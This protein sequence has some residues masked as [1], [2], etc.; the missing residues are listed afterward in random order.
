MVNSKGMF[1][2]AAVAAAVSITS[3][4]FGAATPSE[5][6]QATKGG[7]MGKYAGCVFKAR[8]SLLLTGDLGRYNASVAK[9]NTSNNLA[10]TKAETSAGLGVCPT[11][12]DSTD[13][14]GFADACVEVIM[15]ALGGGT[16]PVDLTACYTDL[17]SCQSSSAIC[18]ADLLTCQDDLDICVN[19]PG[20]GLVQT[21]QTKCYNATGNQQ[22]CAGTGQDAD[23]AAG[24][25]ASFVDNGDGTITDNRTG[26][27]WEKH[28]N[29]GGLH[30][31]DNTYSWAN[32]FVRIDALNTAVFAGHADWRLPNVNELESIM[33]FGVD[34]P[35][36][37]DAFNTACSGS[38]SVTACSC[39][40][41]FD[42]WTSSYYVP[43]PNCAW[44]VGFD[45]GNR[46]GLLK[47][48]LF[49]VRAVRGGL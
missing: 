11:E 48:S 5:K 13:V 49:A 38:C 9:C 17:S 47:T 4:A 33:D 3:S 15:T 2:V 6:C 35:T 19:Q 34:F 23:V 25:T 1:L 29:D 41:S 27:M 46:E 44:S 28:S 7:S 43:D 14:A 30:D 10:F 42:F 18:D 12:G 40:R 32:A 37:G 16:L 26:L 45:L 22:P 36:V 24:Q 39:T 21:G 20:N 31:K 8:R